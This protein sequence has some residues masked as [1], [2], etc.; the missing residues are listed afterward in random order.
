MTARELGDIFKN[1]R[2]KRGMTI[3]DVGRHSR[4]HPNV[5]RDLENGVFDRLGPVYTKGFIKKYAKLLELDQTD[6]LKKYESA[7]RPSGET[8]EQDTLE[9]PVIEKLVEEKILFRKPSKEGS[10]S[11]AGAASEV[12]S[13][14]IMAVVIIIGT[15]LFIFLFR[16]SIRLN[17]SGGKPKSPGCVE[18]PPGVTVKKDKAASPKEEKP[19][20]FRGTAPAPKSDPALPAEEKPETVK[21]KREEDALVL[22]RRQARAKKDVD[23]DRLTLT[24]KARGM[25]WI[26][27]FDDDRTVFVGT[28]KDG[29]SATLKSENNLTVWTGKGENL[30]FVINGRDLGKAVDGVVRDIEVSRGGMKVNGKWIKRV[31]R[32]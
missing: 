15:I 32:S 6:I 28:L 25:V 26:Q 2:E 22:S 9:R 29:E 14:L 20:V 7:V 10:R 8:E 11:S 18:V 31:D 30:E 17:M 13:R 12:R 3:D 4:M 21:A 5:I 27:V 24:L 19:A 16:F 1:T 23:S